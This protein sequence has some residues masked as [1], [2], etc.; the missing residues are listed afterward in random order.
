MT[1]R[2]A[3][4]L[5]VAIRGM[6]GVDMLHSDGADLSFAEHKYWYYREYP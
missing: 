5:T 3:N 6:P 4:R 2:T 1:N